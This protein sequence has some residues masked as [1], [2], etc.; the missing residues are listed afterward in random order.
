VGF[1]NATSASLAPPQGYDVDALFHADR[2]QALVTRFASESFEVVVHFVDRGGVRH[3]VIEI[4]QGTRT[5]VASKSSL[6]NAGG[7]LL[8]RENRVLIR[9]LDSNNTPS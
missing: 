9:T 4:P 2:I 6:A 1:D 7:D 3:P 8:V 5:P